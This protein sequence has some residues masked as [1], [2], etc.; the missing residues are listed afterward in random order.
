MITAGVLLVGHTAAT[1]ADIATVHVGNAGNLGFGTEGF[2]GVDYEYRIGKYE[3]TNA[4]YAEF[5]NGVDPTGTNGFDLYNTQMQTHVNGGITR[6]LSD[7]DGAK[8]SVKS[9]YGQKPVVFV[10]W[11]DS[12]RFANWL[13][14]GQGTGDTETGAYTLLGGT[15]IP[16]DPT[17]ITRNSGAKW[18]LASEN[19]WYKAA[20]HK[21]DGETGN[22]FRYSNGSDQTSYSDQPGDSDAPDPTRAANVYRQDFTNNGYD[23][24]Y[25]VTGDTGFP[26]L[27]GINGLTDVGSYTQTTTPYGA[28]DMTGNVIEWNETILA[29]LGDLPV[30]GFRGE[31]YNS[32]IYGGNFDDRFVRRVGSVVA[33]NY[34]DQEI[35]F[36]VVQLVPEPTS[37]LMLVAAMTLLNARRRFCAGGESSSK[38]AL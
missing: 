9:D 10:S 29:I 18:A 35:G 27:A 8:Y 23:D 34:A 30:Q 24:G 38:S 33:G 11:Y 13:H 17:S 12:L 20:Y 22:Y 19:E 21:N 32:A 4:Q 36:R 16:S 7:A 3:V 26:E 1:A 6:N 15:V 2:G 28:M 37:G 14:N 25:A 31:S 5:L